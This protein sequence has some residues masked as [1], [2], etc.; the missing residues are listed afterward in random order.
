M[1]LRTVR[2]GLRVFR[3]GSEG[4]SASFLSEVRRQAP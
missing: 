1:W 3:Y 2:P 4:N